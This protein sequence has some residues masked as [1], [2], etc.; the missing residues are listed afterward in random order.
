MKKLNT[1]TK[2]IYYKNMQKKNNILKLCFNK[3]KGQFVYLRWRILNK[4]LIKI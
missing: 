3:K 4:I 2:N 1:Q